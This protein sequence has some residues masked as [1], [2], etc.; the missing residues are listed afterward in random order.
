MQGG[1]TQSS[2]ESTKKLSFSAEESNIKN[3]TKNE[4]LKKQETFIKSK[5]SE[6]ETTTQKVWYEA[7]SEEGYKYYWNAVTSGIINYLASII[8]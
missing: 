4:E 5:L 2:I 1:N 7:M 6:I 8:W 3:S